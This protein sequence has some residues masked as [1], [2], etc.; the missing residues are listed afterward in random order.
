MRRR[1]TSVYNGSKASVGSDDHSPAFVVPRKTDRH[2]V[3]AELGRDPVQF[4]GELSNGFGPTPIEHRLFPH[5][6]RA[7][8]GVIFQTLKTVHYYNVTAI[9]TPPGGYPSDTL[10]LTNNGLVHIDMVPRHMRTLSSR[11]IATPRVRTPKP[12]HPGHTEAIE[13]R[14]ADHVARA[15]RLSSKPV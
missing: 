3:R 9:V 15:G 13:H 14:L 5:L 7:C 12:S 8:R 6:T 10:A 1:G 2:S 11:R 4:A